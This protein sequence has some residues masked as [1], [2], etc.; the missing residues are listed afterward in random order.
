MSGERRTSPEGATTRRSWWP[1]WIWSVPIAALGIG[2]W[3][4]VRL[5]VQGGTDI[6][7]TFTDAGGVAAQDTSIEYRG[8]T[9]GTVTGVALT[10][11]GGAVHVE[12]TVDDAVADLLRTG[13][14]FWLRGTHPSL[15]D[16]ASL[17]SIL[18]GPTIVMEPGPG[19]PATTFDGRQ[20]EP[21]VPRDHGRAVPYAVA[22]EGDVGALTP[23]DAVTLR[24][25]PVG[26]V[27][28]IGF[29]YDEATDAIETP[30]TLALYPKL[31]HARGGS[32]AAGAGGSAG[33]V[34]QLISQGMRASLDRDPPVIGGYRVTLEML[35]GT[36]P[37]SVGTVAGLPAIP[38]A[39]GGGL[40]R[41]VHRL[42]EVPFDRIGQHVLD[43]TR[44]VDA[45]AASPKLQHSIALLEQSLREIRETVQEVRPEL[46][47]L[48]GTLR[49]AAGQLDE[50]AGTL[51][52]TL[53]GPASQ[54]GVRSTMRE[55]EEAARAVRGL[56]DYLDRHPE[57]LISGRRGE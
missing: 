56:A 39:P 17:G 30:V 49:A 29:Q 41:I 28:A 47:R 11:D 8:I 37:A 3:L 32:G 4:L 33:V 43:L 6:T 13:T 42:G 36:E 48:T 31:F 44:H 40:G 54:T 51:D 12:A 50:T 15:G 38:V 25:F 26:E 57:A 9:V 5:L 55:V 24:G 27:R 35:P 22:F 53:G 19:D 14:I 46:G 16:L 10:D 21:P 34:T 23:G 45:I 2:I 20:R 52:R 18:S 7:I 1:G